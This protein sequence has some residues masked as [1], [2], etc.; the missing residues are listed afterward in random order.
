MWTIRSVLQLF[1]TRRRSRSVMYWHHTRH[2]SPPAY[3]DGADRQNPRLHSATRTRI[4]DIL[5][6]ADQHVIQQ[7]CCAMY[8]LEQMYGLFLDLLARLWRHL[9]GMGHLVATFRVR[10]TCGHVADGAIC[11]S[12]IQR[13]PER[14]VGNNRLA[15]LGKDLPGRSHRPDP[16]TQVQCRQLS[17]YRRDLRI[18]SQDIQT[19]ARAPTVSQSTTARPCRLPRGAV[20]APSP[21]WLSSPA[22]RRSTR[23]AAVIAAIGSGPR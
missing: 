7:S 22:L 3:Q 16:F 6:V 21:M 15:D 8:A 19:L 20:R 1:P 18:T 13:M 11:I 23:A 14:R 2:E 12:G 4:V 17:F 10:C 9:A 5:P